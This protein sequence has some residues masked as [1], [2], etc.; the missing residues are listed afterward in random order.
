MLVV[1]GLRQM[2]VGV[3]GGAGELDLRPGADWD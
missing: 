3:G 1:Q 2:L